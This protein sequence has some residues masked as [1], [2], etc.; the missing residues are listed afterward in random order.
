MR[1]KEQRMFT[2]LHGQHNMNI[3]EVSLPLKFGEHQSKLLTAQNH[4]RTI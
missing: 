4:T 3:R 1:C 2:E